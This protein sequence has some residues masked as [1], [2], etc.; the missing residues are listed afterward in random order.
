VEVDFLYKVSVTILFAPHQLT[1]PSG[2]II[3]LAI[4]ILYVAMPNLDDSK[5]NSERIR[6]LDAVGGLLSVVWPIPLIFALQEAGV[7][8]AW[9]SNV[10]IG[11][12]TAGLVLCLTFGLYEAWVTYRTTREPIFPMHFLANPA[13]GMTLL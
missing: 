12:L 6:G 4:I 3:S 1:I 13:M 5:T 2:P 11:T 9:S 10:I 8:H 7:A